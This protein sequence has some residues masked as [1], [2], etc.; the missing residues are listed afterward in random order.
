MSKESGGLEVRGLKEFNI[1]LLGKWCLRCWSIGMWF[2]VL[3]SRYCEERGHIKEGGRDGSA[4]WTEI[5]KSREGIS[6]E[7]GRWFEESIERTVGN[8]L[9]IYFWT[10][11]W[12]GRLHS[13]RGLGIFL[14][15]RFIRTRRWQRC[16]P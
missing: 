15:Y 16:I 13:G 1:A 8:D 12:V 4:W 2:R 3:S 14:N 5:V 9:T 7:G 10:D 11:C 6:G